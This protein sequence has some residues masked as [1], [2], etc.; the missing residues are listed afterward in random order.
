MIPKTVQRLLDQI[1][2]NQEPERGDD[3][4]KSHPALGKFVSAV[5]RRA[6]AH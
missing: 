3:S 4:K 5:S 6:G 2:R 1:M